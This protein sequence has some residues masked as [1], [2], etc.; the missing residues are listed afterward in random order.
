M[1]KSLSCILALMMIGVLSLSSCSKT[2]KPEETP[3]T[4]ELETT[5]EAETE[6]TTEAETEPADSRTW[7]DLTLDNELFK[8]FEEFFVPGTTI[9]EFVRGL[10]ATGIDWNFDFD[11]NQQLAPNDYLELTLFRGNGNFFLIRAHNES[12]EACALSSA[13]LELCEL[14][15]NADASVCP[16]LSTLKYDDIYALA[17]NELHDFHIVESD[18]KF[19]GKPSKNISFIRDAVDGIQDDS[20]YPYI[21]RSADGNLKCIFIVDEETQTLV[22]VALYACFQVNQRHYVHDTLWIGHNEWL[23]LSKEDGKALVTSRRL[24]S[25]DYYEQEE[26]KDVTWETCSIRSYLNG[27]YLETNFSDKE[28]ERILE[29]SVHTANNPDPNYP[30]SLGGNDTMDKIF[31]LS[32]EE[33]DGFFA[34]DSDRLAGLFGDQFFSNSCWWL[35]TPGCFNKSAITVFNDSGAISTYGSIAASYTYG[36]RP[37]MWYSLE[38]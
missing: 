11:L 12:D 34:D 24:V 7:K 4:T 23:I 10:K 19:N 36:I 27:D 9:G 22:S 6:T 17:E 29:T 2:E 1:K 26:D 8:V 35:R 31:L 14:S 30:N 18:S 15:D 21:G 25:N 38:P 33:A 37:A 28:K 20:V 16:S 5:T 3:I 32:Y 13:L